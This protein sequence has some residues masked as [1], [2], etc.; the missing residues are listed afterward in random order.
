M[1]LSSTSLCE[2]PIHTAASRWSRNGSPVLGWRKTSSAPWLRM[3]EL[4]AQGERASG[5]GNVRDVVCGTTFTLA[6]YPQDHANQEYLVLSAQFSATE[7][8]ETSGLGEYQISTSFVVQPATTVFRSPRTVLKP[9]TR[10]PQP[11]VVTGP[12]GSELWTDQYGRVKLKFLWDRSPV[13]DQNSS[14][15][16]RVSYAWAG[17]NYGG[18]NIPRVGS[19]VIVDFEN[20]DPDRPIVIGRVYNA[21]NMPPWSLPGNATQSGTLSRSTKGGGYGTANAIRFE[22]KKGHEEVWIH[23]EKDMRTEVENDALVHVGH[24]RGEVIDGMQVMQV[25]KTFQL[26]AGDRISMRTGL[27]EMVME[28]NGDITINGVNINILGSSSVRVDGKIIDLN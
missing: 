17:N 16:V 1:K 6:G 13:R 19:E 9:R 27:S 21:L 14:C 7:T 20:G 10:G 22:D 2:L 23:A 15:W 24:N 12:Q 3:E 8:S 25:G 4:R 26:T 18:I 5:S 11:A 28:S